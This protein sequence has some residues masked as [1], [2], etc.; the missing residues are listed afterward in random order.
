MF[1]DKPTVLLID[2][3]ENTASIF[4]MLMEH[5][6]L[7]Y[8]VIKEP[9]QVIDYLHDNSPSIILID[10]F[11]PGIDG[12]QMLEQVRKASRRADCRILATTAYYSRDTAHTVLE[13]GF[14]GYIPKPFVP[15]TFL[16]YLTGTPGPG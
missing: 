12:F 2:D 10:L 9:I 4:E 11:L 7:S 16:G 6:H 14:D 8:D 5:F 3:D 13:R 15:T 1:D